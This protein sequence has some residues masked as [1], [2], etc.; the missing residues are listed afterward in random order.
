MIKKSGQK[1]LTDV[2]KAVK[3]GNTKFKEILMDT[4]R[5]RLNITRKWI[6]DGEGIKKA[7]KYWKTGFLSAKLQNYSLLHVNNMYYSPGS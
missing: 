4:K 2:I 1:G 7:F 5:L 3:K 6:I